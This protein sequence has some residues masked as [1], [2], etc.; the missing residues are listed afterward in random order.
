MNRMTTLNLKLP[1]RVEERISAIPIEKINGYVVE[2]LTNL[3]KVDEVKSMSN[4]THPL[5]DE[6][7]AQIKQEGEIPREEAFARLEQAVK[8]INADLCKSA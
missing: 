3:S 5:L 2:F 1:E 7:R 4:R 8:E 6:V